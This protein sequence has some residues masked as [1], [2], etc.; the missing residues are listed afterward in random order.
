MKKK[1][2]KNELKLLKEFFDVT[3]QEMVIL[4]QLKHHKDFIHDANQRFVLYSAVNRNLSSEMK[5][6][7]AKEVASELELSFQTAQKNLNY[8]VKQKYLTKQQSLTDKRI[9]DYLPTD[10]AINMVLGWEALRLN[11]YKSS[12]R[13]IKSLNISLFDIT[14][15]CTSRAKNGCLL[16]FL[17][18]FCE[19]F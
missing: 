11:A 5:P 6:I 13:P 15:S 3:Y 4:S 9:F 14:K 19:L 18:A 16:A 7:N 2:K 1:L 12:K 10:D 8:L 17:K